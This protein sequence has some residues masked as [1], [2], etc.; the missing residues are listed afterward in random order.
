MQRLRFLRRPPARAPG[1]DVRF[2]IFAQGRTG[3]SLLRSLLNQ[4]PDVSCDGEILSAA[5][6]DALHLANERAAACARR[7]Y[8]F[9]AKIYQLTDVQ[10]LDAADFLR[11]LDDAGFRLIYLWRRNLLHHAVSNAFAE[12]RGRY[13][14]KAGES[15]TRPTVRLDPETIIG[16]M[17]RR[18]RHLE[19]ERAALGDLPRLELVYEDALLDAADHQ[20]TA[21]RVF[22]YLGLQPVAVVTELAKSAAGNLRTLVSNYDELAAALS[23]TDLEVYLDGGVTE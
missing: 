18:R 22:A 1:A 5:V 17:R 10:H 20:V 9:K 3:S 11:S 23:G 6:N 16:A 15:S 21:R 7:A 8:G 14:D 19:A 4:H 13:H 12:R 2:V